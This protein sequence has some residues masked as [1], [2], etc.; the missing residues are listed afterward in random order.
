MGASDDGS[1]VVPPPPIETVTTVG[2]PQDGMNHL[3]SAISPTDHELP[4][5]PKLSMGTASTLDEPQRVLPRRTDRNRNQGPPAVRRLSSHS[6]RKRINWKGKTLVI[7][8]PYNDDRGNGTTKPRLLLPADYAKILEDWEQQGYD[9]RG[10]GLEDES[11]TVHQDYTYSLS[12]PIFPAPSDIQQEAREGGY[13][14]HFPDLHRQS[15][16][17]MTLSFIGQLC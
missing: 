17:T 13:R 12:R 1:G 15:S 16:L 9:T 2:S 8:P 10:F 4:L 5:P 14:V 11:R 3:E 6:G 7:A